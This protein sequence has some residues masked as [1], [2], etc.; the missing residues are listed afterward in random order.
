MAADQAAVGVHQDG[1]FE[2][3]GL[4]AVSDLADLLFAVFARVVLMGGQLGNGDGFDG[5]R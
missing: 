5:K 4:D 2:P 1:D 3:E